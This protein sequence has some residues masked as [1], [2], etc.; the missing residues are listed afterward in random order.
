MRKQ[1]Y[2][3]AKKTRAFSLGA[4]TFFSH[5]AIKAQLEKN[6]LCDVLSARLFNKVRVIS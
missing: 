3:F 5:K 4:L 6:N 2:V 1:N